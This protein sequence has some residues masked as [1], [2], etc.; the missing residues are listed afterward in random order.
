MLKRYGSA[1]RIGLSKTG[2]AVVRT[3]GW[4]QTRSVVVAEFDVA[5][6]EGGSHEA[7]LTQLGVLLKDAQCSRLPVRIVLSD[8]WVR[9]WMVIPPQNAASLADCQAAAAARFQ[10]LFGEPMSGWNMAADWDAARPF[11]ACAIPRALLAGLQQ[12]ARDRDLVLLEVAPQFVVAWNRWRANLQEGAWFGVL[13]RQV[14]T[15]AVVG[16]NG[17]QATREVELPIDALR[18]QQRVPAILAREALRLNVPMP[19]EIRLC[20]QIP[21]HWAMQQTGKVSFVRL[22]RSRSAHAPLSAGAALAL[23]G[24]PS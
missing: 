8:S 15:L 16:R 22:D 17:P 7:V 24:M 9:R 12:I 4:K 6:D 18:D 20:G 13:H 3:S 5:A 11:L 10:A 1:L 21:A 2:V 23:T 19:Q 14:L